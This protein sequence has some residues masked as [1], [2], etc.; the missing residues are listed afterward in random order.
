MK[1]YTG[2]IDQELPTDM[3]GTEISSDALS[4]E[5]MTFRKKSRSVQLCFVF[6]GVS[7]R[8][9]R[10]GEPSGD[11]ETEDQRVREIGDIEIQERLG[12]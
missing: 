10:C 12:S 9:K 6:I 8:H 3:T 11:D 2:A 5:S 7:V 1:A 4:N